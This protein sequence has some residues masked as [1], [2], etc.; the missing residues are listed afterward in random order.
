[1]AENVYMLGQKSHVHRRRRCQRLD[2]RIVRRDVGSQHHNV[3][4]AVAQG[5]RQAQSDHGGAAATVAM[6]D[7]GDFH[8]DGCKRL[9]SRMPS[10][11]MTTMTKAAISSVRRGR[12]SHI[13]GIS[14]TYIP[15]A[16]NTAARTK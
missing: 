4:S 5:V 7:K 9:G 15:T 12:R 2:H 13:C 6:C 3:H 8:R 1:M 10:W 11:R 14:I 16:Y